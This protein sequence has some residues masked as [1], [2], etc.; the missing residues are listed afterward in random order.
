M[1]ATEHSVNDLHSNSFKKIFEKYFPFLKFYSEN[2]KSFPI[3]NPCIPL[4]VFI[5]L[6]CLL[7]A[8][9]SPLKA[10]STLLTF[11]TALVSFG[12]FNNYIKQKLPQKYYD[13][14]YGNGYWNAKHPTSRIH[15]LS[16]LD[17]YVY[18]LPLILSRA[19]NLSGFDQNFVKKTYQPSIGKTFRLVMP[20]KYKHLSETFANIFLKSFVKVLVEITCN[21]ITTVNNLS[22]VAT[23]QTPE[24]IYNSMAYKALTFK[25][26]KVT[27]MIVALTPIQYM[28]SKS[29]GNTAVSQMIISKVIKELIEFLVIDPLV[30]FSQVNSLDELSIDDEINTVFNESLNFNIT[31]MQK[32]LA[33]DSRV[34]SATRSIVGEFNKLQDNSRSNVDGNTKL[35]TRFVDEYNQ[36]NQMNDERK[37]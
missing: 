8:K 36:R 35:T 37:I 28:L 20:T 26:L 4:V 6:A 27:L 16:V 30:A 24:N 1:L 3:A 29:I 5:G 34:N 17:A 7:N 14:F 33:Q 25:L 9:N 18:A 15:I 11:S 12:A 21:Q 32:E 2:N 23:K 13:N 22:I 10:F 19:L 31:H